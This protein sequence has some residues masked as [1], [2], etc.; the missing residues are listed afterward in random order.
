MRE[1]RGSALGWRDPGLSRPKA[2]RF[3]ERGLTIVCIV[4]L[5]VPSAT[6]SAQPVSAERSTD[7]TGAASTPGESTLP[8]AVSRRTA[9]KKQSAPANAATRPKTSADFIALE[10]QLRERISAAP[11][12]ASAWDA[13]S[14]LLELYKRT[15]RSTAADALLAQA[16][17]RI[18]SDA[19]GRSVTAR[20]TRLDLKTQTEPT[21]PVSRLPGLGMA[22]G[23]LGLAVAPGFA[24]EVGD[25]AFFAPD[26]HTLDARA[27][28]V[29]RAQAAWLRRNNR[30]QSIT[31]EG[32]ADDPGSEQRNRRLAR[33]RAEA[34]RAALIQLGVAPQRIVTRTFGASNRIALCT[35][36]A[37][38]RQN[39]RVLT[40][41]EER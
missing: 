23:L 30:G 8:H 31:I 14:E 25:R 3:V 19:T 9:P 36:A 2:T 34:V 27:L 21:M 18:T 1:R 4:V 40:V 24:N 38:R 29:I 5:L 17:P 22:R 10:S 39:R 13:R 11:N 7:R 16:R 33:L 26:V 15:G 28:D 12:S 20:D 35:S 6:S 41:V 32:H 37:C